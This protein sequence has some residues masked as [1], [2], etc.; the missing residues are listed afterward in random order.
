[1]STNLSLLALKHAIVK[2]VQT[3]NVLEG[4]Q[5]KFVESISTNHP[6][7]LIEKSLLRKG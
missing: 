4:G 3:V 7:R 1:M 6:S 5:L 2:I